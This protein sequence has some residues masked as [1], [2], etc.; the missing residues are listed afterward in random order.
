MDGLP[1]GGAILWWIGVAALFLVV[2]PLVLT[3]ALR[4]ITHIREIKGYAD[5]ALVH[6]L[7]VTENLDPVPALLETRDLVKSAS[8]KFGQ[9][10]STVNR[11]L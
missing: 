10:V 5:D 8:G 4:V 9:Y 2:I 6:G 3:L 11:L 7:A 1:T